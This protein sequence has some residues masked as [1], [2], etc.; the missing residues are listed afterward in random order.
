MPEA[1]PAPSVD[2]LTVHRLST[3]PSDLG[4]S[5]LWW[6]DDLW[7]IDGVAGRIHCRDGRSF[8]LGGHIGGIA[9]ASDGRLVFSPPELAPPRRC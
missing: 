1:P 3:T 2:G 7:W 6:Q 9:P 5:P 8:D 4:E